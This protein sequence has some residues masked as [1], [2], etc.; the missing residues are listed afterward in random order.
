M[1]TI[2]YLRYLKLSKMEKG[3]LFR[4][5][6]PGGMKQMISIIENVFKICKRPESYKKPIFSTQK[7]VEFGF[8][9]ESPQTKSRL[10]YGIWYDA[11]EYFETPIVI[12]F[13]YYGKAPVNKLSQV[14]EWV[15]KKDIKGVSYKEFENYGIIVF[16]EIFFDFES[17]AKRMYTLLNDLNA[18]LEVQYKN[19]NP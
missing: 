18:F 17:D 19:E 13:Q 1:Q 14:K 7:F 6:I 4:K 10:F 16:Q 12:T 15:E 9:L 3:V 11:W 5:E 2:K 8:Y